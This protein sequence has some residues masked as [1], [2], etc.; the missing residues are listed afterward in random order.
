MSYRFLLAVFALS[1][2]GLQTICVAQQETPITVSITTPTPVTK[3][4]AEVRINVTV[5]NKSD[6]AVKLYKALGPDG[7]AEAANQI[8]VLDGNGNK[9]SRID[10]R[11]VQMGGQ[12]YHLPKQWIS[13]TT[14]HVEPGQSNN[15]F[16]ILSNLFDL[17]KP[18][19]YAVTI[20]H[21]MRTSS[22]GTEDKL[23]D[24]P[25]NTITITVT[26]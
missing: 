21:E 3:I 23:I 26:E 6:H 10:G 18:G 15:D 20:R 1:T 12:S 16:L 7:Q 17:N 4:G 8:D 14:V 19:Q 22:P 25:S 24:V 13:R 9:L 5:T 11:V 2:A